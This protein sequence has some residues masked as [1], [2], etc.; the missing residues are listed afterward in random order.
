MKEEEERNRW[1]NIELKQQREL[2]T[3]FGKRTG[4]VLTLSKPPNKLFPTV[5]PVSAVDGPPEIINIPRGKYIVCT[6]EFIR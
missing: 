2:T 1:E 4:V 6:V 5:L 3:V